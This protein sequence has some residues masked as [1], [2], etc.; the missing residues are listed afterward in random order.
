MPAM[1]AAIYARY[2]TDKQRETSI[3]DQLRVCVTR[4]ESMGC[5]I[6]ATYADNGVSGSVPVAARAGGRDLL[7]DNRFQLLVIEGLDRLSRDL[8]EQETVVRRLE[9]RGVRI[10]GVADGYDSDMAGRI[11]HRGM[12]GIINQVY[13]DDL[14]HKTHRGLAG[15]FDRGF[16]AGGLTYGYRSVPGDIGSV[17]EV[18]EEQAAVVRDIFEAFVGG[19]TYKGIARML[20]ERGI[21]SPRQSTWSVSAIY[22]SPAKGTGILNNDLYRGVLI[23]NRS[24]WEKDPDTK[25]RVRIER[26]ASEWKRQDAPE[27]RIVSD[28]LWQAVKRR[29]NRPR[30]TGGAKCKGGVQRHLLSGILRCGACGG[31]MIAVNTHSYGCSNRLNRGTC[32]FRHTV[33]RAT[34]E[35]RI[36]AL[37]RRDLLSPEAVDMLKRE[38]R[39]ELERQ[40]D[41]AAE[42]EKRRQGLEREI[43]NLTQAIADM[44]MSRALQLRLQEAEAELSTM[45][46]PV[47]PSPD[48]VPR[49]LDRYRAVIDDMRSAAEAREALADLLGEVPLVHDGEGLVAELGGLYSGVIARVASVG[50]VAGACF[51]PYRLPLYGPEPGL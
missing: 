23:W 32:D 1:L 10:V 51:E 46:V 33:T 48:F 49:L 14:R 11:I 29:Q 50:M 15:Q 19:G 28:E 9:F 30:E 40:P 21:R 26:P 22:G 7:A 31:P 37:V 25:R 17:L 27:L 34:V 35:R 39:A 20:N 12:R 3:D 47:Q 16:H 24:R 44:G 8:A 5:S 42:N 4:A 41:Q 13:L 43:R 38:V 36:I 6:V 45:E 2:S 18:V